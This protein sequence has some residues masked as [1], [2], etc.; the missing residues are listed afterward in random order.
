[1]RAPNETADCV[2]TIFMFLKWVK[3]YLIIPYIVRFPIYRRNKKKTL[4]EW[5][6]DFFN[7]QFYDFSHSLTVEPTPATGA[8]IW[9]FASLAVLFF[10]NVYS[11]L[12]RLMRLPLGVFWKRCK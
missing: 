11:R 2:K 6:I 7:L 9:Y 10:F 4:L 3:G 1:M 8:R 5:G 12:A